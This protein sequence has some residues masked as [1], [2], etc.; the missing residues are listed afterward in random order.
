MTEVP[1]ELKAALEERRADP[2]PREGFGSSTAPVVAGDL[3][4]ITALPHE[5]AERRIGL[6]LRVEAPDEFADIM[7]VHSAP[8]LATD[9]DAIVRAEVV[10]ALYDI[11][12]QT[13]LRAVVW[14]L[15]IGRCVA[16]LD[17]QS[18]AAIKAIAGGGTGQ[19]GIT[20]PA[21]ADAGMLS[22][23]PLA[24]P[25]DAR[26]SFKESEGEVLRRLASDCTEALLDGDRVWQV[27]Q[28]LLRPEIL[29]TA[30]HPEQLLGEFLH[31]DRTRQLSLTD[32]DLECL[33]E[34]GA[35]DPDSWVRA[36][37]IGVEV[38]MCVHG[39]VEQVATGVHTRTG[40]E[41]QGLLTVAGFS[42]R[43]KTESIER[44]HYLKPKALETA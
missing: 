17:D 18:L 42:P 40:H 33:L 26:W 22:G 37:D 6:V 23:P 9:R 28:N 11:V 41:R 10:S 2:A 5:P 35:L 15:Q 43:C 30:E 7:L 27:D 4:V 12:V 20:Q 24:G 13:D 34:D 8:E 3:R 32:E 29:G 19:E 21:I 31:W 39:L 36:S 38:L 25:L 14:T 1:A 16:R 44:I